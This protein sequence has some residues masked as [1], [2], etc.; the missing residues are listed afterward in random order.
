MQ[1]QQ[2]Q[3]MQQQQMQQQQMQQQM[4][5]PMPMQQQIKLPTAET[6]E[7]IEQNTQFHMKKR[8]LKMT[9]EEFYQWRQVLGQY[10]KELYKGIKI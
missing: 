10:K 9:Y 1:Q 5:Q 2:Q 7:T 4:Q 8:I 6:M 3:Q